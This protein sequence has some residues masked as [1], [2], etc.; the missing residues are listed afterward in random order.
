MK[1]F[2]FTLDR[3]KQYRIQIE[4]MEKND[5]AALRAD[6]KQLQ[7][8]EQD[9]WR[10]ILAKSEELRR[11]LR[12]G[13]FPNE[14][15]VANRYLTFKKQE[16]EMKKGEI[17]DKKKEIEN[18]LLDVM[19]ATKEVKKLEKLEEHQLEEYKQMEVKENESFLEEFFGGARQG[20]AS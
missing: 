18:K 4:D 20:N 14:I 13:A 15:S 12:K 2:Q 1:K 7:E 5:L 17:E 10:Q 8:Q 11:L 9:I 6:L 19:E 3:I 16:L